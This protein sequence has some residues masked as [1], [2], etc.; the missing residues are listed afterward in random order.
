MR[1]LLDTQLVYWFFFEEQNVSAEAWEVMG[2]ADDVHV[3]A[4]SIWEIAIKVRIGKMKADPYQIA[5]ALKDAGFIELPVY[6]RHTVL[7]AKMPMHHGDPFDR[8][9]IAQ[10]ME[11]PMHL[12]TTDTHL[13][14]Y[15]KLVIEV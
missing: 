8:L 4:V 9:L 6:A 12:L 1:V 15:S 5:T 10:A 13:K 11:E 7:V 14:Q 3:S 2:K